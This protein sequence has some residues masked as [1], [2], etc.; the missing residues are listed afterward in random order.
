MLQKGRQTKICLL[1]HSP[2]GHKPGAWSSIHI[3]P[4]GAGG[5]TLGPSAAFSGAFAG[6]WTG[7]RAAGV[8]LAPHGMPESQAAAYPFMDA[9]PSHPIL[10][11]PTHPSAKPAPLLTLNQNPIPSS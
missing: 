9:L 10:T 5:Q 2:Y 11:P 4:A 1:D 8:E 6:S 3:T 7:S